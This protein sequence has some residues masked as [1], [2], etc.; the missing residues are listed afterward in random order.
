MYRNAAI[1]ARPGYHRVYGETTK[2]AREAS[3]F[4]HHLSMAGWRGEAFGE[5]RVDWSFPP[6]RFELTGPVGSHSSM[7]SIRADRGKACRLQHS[8]VGDG[9]MGTV[10]IRL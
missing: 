1:T 6:D 7:L 10:R 5:I 9:N 2:H 4:T 8:M 3:V